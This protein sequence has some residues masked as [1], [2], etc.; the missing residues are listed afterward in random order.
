MST[1]I[2]YSAEA[3]GA[4]RQTRKV[5][6]ARGLSYEERPANEYREYLAELNV[7]MALPIVVPP[8]GEPFSGF[9]PER[10]VNGS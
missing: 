10:L 8:S 5:L 9:R 3:C 7:G 6:A 4:C 2:I 1:Y